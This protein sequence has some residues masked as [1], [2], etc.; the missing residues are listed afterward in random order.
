MS[1]AVM[2]LVN[3]ALTPSIKYEKPFNP[4]RYC[5]MEGALTVRHQSER[6]NLY[7]LM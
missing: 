5:S 3:E 1:S 6:A 7:G 4:N 2:I